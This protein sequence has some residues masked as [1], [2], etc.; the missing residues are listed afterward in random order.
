MKM[1]GIELE[2]IEVQTWIAHGILLIGFAFLTIRLLEL[3]WQIIVGRATGFQ[4][5]DE[6]EESLHLANELREEIGAGGGAK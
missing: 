2:D 3:F 1:I 6:A 4:K 5:V